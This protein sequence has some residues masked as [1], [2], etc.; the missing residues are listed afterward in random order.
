MTARIRCLWP[1][2]LATISL[3]LS[4]TPAIA[5][6]VTEAT[7]SSFFHNIGHTVEFSSVFV[8]AMLALYATWKVLRKPASQRP[9][10]RP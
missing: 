7:S 1:K 2:K 10:K 6:T 8:V 4:A 3:L 9:K 5:H